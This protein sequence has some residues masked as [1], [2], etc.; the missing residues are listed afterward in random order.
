MPHGP[1]RL[2]EIVARF[3]GELV[4]DQ[5]VV[6]RQVGTL[7]GAGP[8]ELSFLSHPRYRG[9]LAATRASAVIVP[10]TARGATVLPRIVCRDP[11]A[12][13][14]RVST[15]FN[16]PRPSVPTWRTVMSG[17]PTSSPPNRATISAR[18]N[19]PAGIAP[20]SLRA[21]CRRAPG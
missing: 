1:F 13:F 17:S 4:G 18:R 8:G 5:D 7:S 14:A 20:T 9:E 15:L 11:Y 10:E 19:G 12:Y 3:G 16:P 6:V 21:S 2:A